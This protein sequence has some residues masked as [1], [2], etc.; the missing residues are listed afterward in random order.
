MY[1]Y[2]SS[3]QA[4]T[5]RREGIIS[6][7]MEK[8]KIGFIFQQTPMTLLANSCRL[9]LFVVNFSGEANS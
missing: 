6:L 9:N 7:K 3:V 5:F 1:N 8:D 4:Q 2:T